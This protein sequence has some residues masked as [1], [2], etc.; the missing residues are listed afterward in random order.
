[1]GLIV[2][3][4]KQPIQAIGMNFREHSM[5]GICRNLAALALLEELSMPQRGIDS[6][7]S[8]LRLRLR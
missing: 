8:L 5:F 6:H 1:M 2:V 4:R 3:T 7:G